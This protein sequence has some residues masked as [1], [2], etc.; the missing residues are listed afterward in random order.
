MQ[1]WFQDRSPSAEVERSAQGAVH[2]LQ[3]LGMNAGGGRE[4]GHVA[5][6][7]LEHGQP[8]ALVIGG[9]E[10]GVGG[11]DPQ[12]NP[13]G[14]DRSE[15]EQLDLHRPRQCERAVVALLGA[16]GIGSEQQVGLL[17]V[18][19]QLGA[20]LRAGEW[21]EALEIHAAGQH[22]R[23]F[24]RRTPGQLAHERGGDGGE[25]IDQRQRG[26]GRQAGA[27]V[28]QVGAVHG[29]RAHAGGNGEGRPGGEA[30]VGVDDVEALDAG[31]PRGKSPAQV[32][33][34]ACQRPPAG[35]NS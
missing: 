23:T 16:G 6:E 5:G 15:R 8:E 33:S 3:G 28:A 10:D 18:E 34:G 17:G 25:K 24:P 14:V 21:A 4:H 1:M 2:V 27:G 22:L 7:R 31:S 12:R 29:Q 26:P 19:A 35:G 9:H 13:G 32:E 20:R 11:V 30:E